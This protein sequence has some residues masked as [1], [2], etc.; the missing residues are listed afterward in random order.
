MI[1]L[2]EQLSR[3]FYTN[4]PASLR[5]STNSG[6]SLCINGSPPDIT[7]WLDFNSDMYSVLKTIGLN[8]DPVEELEKRKN[9][10]IQEQKLISETKDIAENENES[11]TVYP[12]YEDARRHF[13]E[14]REQNK[15]EN[16]S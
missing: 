4:F 9:Q 8:F 16:S 2:I 11:T 15:Q 12:E 5:A 1:S 14:I 3:R 7:T 13:D 10:K 6:N